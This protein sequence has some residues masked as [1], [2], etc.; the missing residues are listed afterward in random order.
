MNTRLLCTNKPNRITSNEQVMKK[1]IPVFL[2]SATFLAALLLSACGH[3]EAQNTTPPAYLG[4]SANYIRTW[5]PTSPQ[6]SPSGLASAPLTAVKQTTEYMDGF[7]RPMQAVVKQGSPAGNDM[8]TVYNYDQF[9]NQTYSYLPF[10]SNAV[11]G[12][13][14]TNDGTF[15]TD[16]YQQQAAFYTTMF[17]TANNSDASWPY[18]QVNIEASPVKRTLSTYGP[19]ANWVGSQSASKPRTIKTTSQLNA[20]ADNVQMWNIAAAQ[21]SIPT[22]GG[23]YGAGQLFKY[24][25]TD[26]QGNQF[27]EYKDLYGQL[28]LRKVQNSASADNGSSVHVGWLCTYYVYDDYG[29]LR[30]IIT[31]NVVQLI[32]GSWTI[33][34]TLADEYCYRF[35]YD[36]QNRMVIRKIPGTPTGS[37]GE[38]WMVY[39][40]RNR[41]VFSQDGNMR[42]NSQWLCYL[43]DALDRPVMTGTIT[44]SGSLS[45]LQS[46]VS[47]QTGSNSLA[48]PS[49]AT[50]PTIQAN[51]T[52]TSVSMSGTYQASQSIVM[53]PGF[54]SLAN[55]T[56]TAEITAQSPTS[57]VNTVVINNSPIPSGSTVSPLTATFY[58]NYNWQATS[59]ASLSSTL[60]QS[61]IQNSTYFITGY[62]ASPTYAQPIV[63]SSQIQGLP[64]GQMAQEMGTSTNLFALDIYDDHGRLIQAQA[65]NVS[66]GTDISTTQFDWMGKVQRNL[67]A[68]TF[69]GTNAQTYLVG[70]ATTY[71]AMG[72]LLNIS[73]TMSGTINGTTLP[74]VTKTIGAYTYNELGQLK[75][76]TLGSNL[77]TL[78]YDYNIRGWLLGMNRSFAKTASST[79]NYFGYDLGYDQAVIADTY[80][81]QLGSYAAPAF[82]GSI[83]GTVWKSRGDNQIRKY[84]YSY[85]AP[86]RLLG[87]DF[88]QYTSGFSKSAGLDFS[89][90]GLGYDAN[91]NIQQMNQNGWILGGSQQIDKLVY[92]YNN[93]NTSNRLMNVM[94]NSPYNSSN[95]QSTLGDFHYSGSKTTSSVDYTYDNDANATSDA[96]RQISGITYSR[97]LDLPQTI[98]YT[99]SKGTIQY[100]YDA[101]GTKL[102]K[103]VTEN[104]GSVTLNGTAYPTNVTTTTTYILGFVYKSLSYSNTALSSL[105]YTNQL[106]YIG[107]EEGR[108]RALYTTT[109][110]A[111]VPTSFA[112]DYFIRDNTNN[113]R[114]VLTDEQQQ[115]IYPA[116]TIESN[117]IATEQ[118][119]YEITNDAAHV[120]PVSSLAWWTADQGTG[121]ADNNGIANP[122]DPTPTA[123][124]AQVYKLNGQTGSGFGLG[125]T[126]KVMAGDQVS[127]FGK[128]IW[129]NTGTSPGSFPIT[130]VLS[131]LL[132]AF[133][134]TP[135]VTSTTEGA[136][137]GAALNGS[138]ATTGALTTLLQNT[139]GQPNPT[140]APKAAVNWILFNQQF[141]PVSMGT[142]LVSSTA[143]VVQLINQ[144]NI[145]MTANG[146][147]YVYCSNESDID[148]FFDNLQVVNQRGPLL[149]ETHYYPAGLAMAGI[150]A[151]AWN[152]LP[153]LLHYQG[154]EIQ[155]QEFSNG[156]GLEEYDFDSRYYDE[157]LGRWHTQDA[158]G[159]FASPYQAM[160]NNWPNGTDPS[161]KVTGWGDVAAALVGGLINLGS[162]LLSGNVHSIGQGFEYFGVGA[163]DGLAVVNGGSPAMVG[164]LGGVANTV[165]ASAPNGAIN[166][167]NV[168]WQSVT[169]TAIFSSITSSVLGAIKMPVA[170][171][172]GAITWATVEKW[173]VNGVGAAIGNSAFTDAIGPG[174]FS[175]IT[176]SQ[177]WK[178]GIGGGI[179]GVAEGYLGTPS[180][181]GGAGLKDSHIGSFVYADFISIGKSIATNISN[182]APLLSKI[183]VAAGPVTITF[184]QGSNWLQ[185]GANIPLAVDFVNYAYGAIDQAFTRTNP[186]TWGFTSSGAIWT[187]GGLLGTP[188]VPGTD[189][190]KANLTG[191]VLGWLNGWHPWGKNPALGDFLGK[192]GEP[193]LGN[194]GSTFSPQDAW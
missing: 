116:A 188:Q 144:V 30:F 64:T 67:V 173:A 59:G 110:T 88:N 47:S 104:N 69:S 115:D 1:Y 126:I 82:N 99:S 140:V 193:G 90:S 163:I 24:V 143:D 9:G 19:G 85:D 170:P 6:T 133:A 22:S 149:E 77:E 12:G 34:Q 129:H 119:Y 108:I 190:T 182:N 162:E 160:G 100:V 91:G 79:T 174:N 94:D 71:D 68:H 120:I 161:G 81:N 154:K 35:E 187:T 102:Q 123:T 37:G 166:F 16:A 124:S 142:Q 177:L 58:D 26:E 176:F 46:Q 86:N 128:S 72:R 39:D 63:Q 45:Q 89:I 5:E 148:V 98:T 180:D 152:K 103:I 183:N 159:Q 61:N 31:P 132:S 55:G 29:N 65:V 80:G 92:T 76:K 158:A 70:T 8:V 153:N 41:L 156:T 36:L 28:I 164:L 101:G 121:Y 51:L 165:I 60:N 25:T 192:I 40:M 33:S 136:I 147:L 184:G 105:Q 73:K 52:L 117:T 150:S 113:V 43:Y 18:S 185:L 131:S 83:A 111:N 42:P 178:S 32:D 27:I 114:M 145:P 135:V 125:I 2:W 118:N 44:Y 14:A 96:N 95:P 97:Y 134:G 23:A 167:S 38:V 175:S 141:V 107:T 169:E 7:G 84:D 87:A 138:T 78:A 57:P 74:V 137:T 181:D 15:K 93:S 179:M 109:A 75:Q 122:G 10:A 17:P 189:P 130:G 4:T 168:N 49:G 151:T 127:I 157:Q 3:L 191:G 20:A 50:A 171:V 155:H 56:F 106:Q 186:V 21:G 54:S 66:G 172:G 112:F 13:D 53:N 139:P 146:Y 11:Q 194:V 62:N 48:T